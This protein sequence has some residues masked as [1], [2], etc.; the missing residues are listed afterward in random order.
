MF[1][2]S[3]HPAGG[4]AR[5]PEGAAPPPLPPAI[6]PAGTGSP[7]R[8][9]AGA[10]LRV[11]LAAVVLGAGGGVSWYWLTHRPK[12]R[13]RPPRPSAALV[14]VER[15][16]PESYPV[17]VEAM[18]TVQAARATALAPQVSGRIVSTST[19]FVPGG[20]FS[21]GEEMLRIDPAD[22]E[23]AVERLTADVRQLEGTWQKAR[24]DVALRETDVIKADSAYK[25]E[26]GR[27]SVAQREYELLGRTVTA[28][29]LELVL[30]KPELEAAKAECAAARASRAAAAATSSAARAALD[31]SRVALRQA[32]LDLARTVVR[33]PFNAVV[34]SRSAHLGSQASPSSPVAELAGTDAYWVEVCVPVDHLKWLRVPRRAGERGS[35][36]RVHHE[37]AWGAEAH[38]SGEVLRL[39]AELEPQGRMARLL[40]TVRD[41]LGLRPAAPADRPLIL[42][43]YV[44]V[45]IEGRALADAV[46]VSR[47]ALREGGLVWVMTGEDTLDIRAVEIAWSDREHVYVSAGLNAGDLLVTS[48]LGAPVQGMALRTAPST[49]APAT[50]PARPAGGRAGAGAR[51]GRP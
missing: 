21:A 17:V 31:A 43:S 13:R 5:R 28:E 32:E 26:L 38:R 46:R 25:T 6:G 10:V 16:A 8:R 15:V 37:A 23:L 4:E 11:L 14:E 18:G 40:V 27:Q 30:R 34:R 51:G 3:T 1:T 33:A 22:Y 35:P 49:T 7:A 24:N 48:N 41:P 42:G 44:R 50:T 47:T 2:E 12:A 29:D 39:A 36:A 9:G 20:L 45:A 19:A